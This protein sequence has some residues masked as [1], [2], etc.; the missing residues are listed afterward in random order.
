MGVC[1]RG[2]VHDAYQVP[3]YAFFQK[4][5]DILPGPYTFKGPSEGSVVGLGLRLAL[6]L[7]A[8]E[9][10]MAIKSSQRQRLKDVCECVSETG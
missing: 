1:V 5:E 10:A 8:V 4:S 3:K 7:A 9:C 2:C 6:G